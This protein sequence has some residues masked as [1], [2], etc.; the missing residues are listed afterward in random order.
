MTELVLIAEQSDASTV[1]LCEPPAAPIC[2]PEA[3]TVLVCADE[4]AP[5]LSEEPQP[6]LLLTG[7][8]PGPA[9]ASAYALWLLQG[10]SGSVEDFLAALQGAPGAPGD[11][12]TPGDPGD[13][14]DPG[15]SAYELW[16][17][18][19]NSGSLEDFLQS[20][21]G[22][23]GA[24]GPANLYIGTAAGAPT[25]VTEPTLLLLASGDSF[26]LIVRQP[27]A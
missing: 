23:D 18:A 7:G 3:D 1:V 11:P 10:N 5:S 4:P 6:T 20:L 9:G 21:E 19:G 16:L 24:P 8:E 26:Q 15:A 27:S 14:G 2:L 25:N 12:G 13:P 22:Q 17:A